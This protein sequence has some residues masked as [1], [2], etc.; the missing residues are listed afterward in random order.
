[1]QKISSLLSFGNSGSAKKALNPVVELAIDLMFGAMPLSYRETIT[2]VH[3]LPKDFKFPFLRP[4]LLSKIFPI[5]TTSEIS[6][7]ISTLSS[8]TSSGISGFKSPR[9]LS[10]YK[11]FCTNFINTTSSI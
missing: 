4:I 1:M 8:R 10:V 9:E 5:K 3:F 6:I 2:K 11:N 7:P